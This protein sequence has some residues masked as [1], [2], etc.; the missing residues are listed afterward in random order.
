[1]R[2]TTSPSTK[3]TESAGRNSDRSGEP[4]HSPDR[5]AVFAGGSFPARLVLALFSLLLLFGLSTLFGCLRSLERSVPDEFSLLD[6]PFSS[7]LNITSAEAPPLRFESAPKPRVDFGKVAVERPP[8]VKPR[9]MTF[10]E[11]AVIRLTG[12]TEPMT[13]DFVSFNSHRGDTPMLS[14]WKRLG[15]HT[16]LAAMFA[17]AQAPAAPPSDSDKLDE[18]QKQLN[19][20]K[21]SVSTIQKSLEL[22]QAMGTDLRNLRTESRQGVENAE[23]QIGDL[24][25]ELGTLRDELDKLDTELSTPA[26]PDFSQ[27]DIAALA[28]WWR[29]FKTKAV[30]IPLP[31]NA[32][33]CGMERA[34]PDTVVGNQVRVK[35]TFV[36]PEQCVLPVDPL[37]VNRALLQ[38]GCEVRLRWETVRWTSSKGI[39]H[40]KYVLKRGR[41]RLGQREGKLPRLVLESTGCRRQ[42]LPA[43]ETARSVPRYA[44]RCGQE[45]DR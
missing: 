13:G 28:E 9:R 39:E 20:L 2:S 10:A 44:D 33:I 35:L 18:I 8:Q 37:T 12:A 15:L 42:W 11:P 40:N 32:T 24:K 25:R 30:G 31:A 36:P 41:F 6:G 45:A 21:K 22:L 17:V 14:T 38:L 3:R 5:L 29:D 26:D 19:E 4:C 7:N 27:D 43:P 1:M 34:A 23:K 16:L